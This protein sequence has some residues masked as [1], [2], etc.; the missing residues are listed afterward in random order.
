MAIL[1]EAMAQNSQ[2]VEKILVDVSELGPIGEKTE[3]Y[4]IRNANEVY[5]ATIKNLDFAL[6]QTW[7]DQEQYHRQLEAAIKT[8]EQN[9][10]AIRARLEAEKR[11][12]DS[13]DQAAK[14]ILDSL[15]TPWTR[16]A[17][18]ATKIDELLQTG[19]LNDYQAAETHRANNVSLKS[20][21]GFADILTPS[22]LLRDRLF[23]LAQ[24]TQDIFV[25]ETQRKRQTDKLAHDLA[26]ASG[27]GDLFDALPEQQ[28]AKLATALD[29]V[30]SLLAMG[31]LTS[32]QAERM[33]NDAAL[34]Y[35]TDHT[36]TKNPSYVLKGTTEAYQRDQEVLRGGNVAQ[37]QYEEIKKLL[38][39]VELSRKEQEENRRATEQ[40]AENTAGLRTLKPA[41]IS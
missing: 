22:Q 28:M 24:V 40:I 17:E 29:G 5:A 1:T 8:L 27:I 37:K 31:K 13:M 7:I 9:D 38:A 19:H 12:A 18:N 36:E 3:V 11:L 20:S 6:S 10:P 33:K 41:R 34:K 14:N 30:D 35:V 23:N 16:F 25:S 32:E 4:V 15:K 21:L 26:S 2:G 39:E